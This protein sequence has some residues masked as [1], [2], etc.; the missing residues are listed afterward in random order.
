METLIAGALAILV[1]GFIVYRVTRG[2]SEGP[3]GP[4]GGGG[5]G[6]AHHH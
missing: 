6:N 2:K 4:V 1:V 5:G 3:R